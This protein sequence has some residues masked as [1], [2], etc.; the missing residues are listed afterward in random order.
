MV[1]SVPAEAIWAPSGATAK[2]TIGPAWP[3]R[4]TGRLAASESEG[5]ISQRITVASAPADASAAL[6]DVFATEELGAVFEVD[7]HA[8]RIGFEVTFL[9]HPREEF[10]L[11][12][13]GVRIALRGGLFDFAE[14]A[15]VGAD[16]VEVGGH[17]RIVC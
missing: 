12:F 13:D 1:P 9:R 5:A 16:G 6:G 17:I 15:G 14:G 11:D 4:S 8:E 3:R 10:A 2:V 7:A